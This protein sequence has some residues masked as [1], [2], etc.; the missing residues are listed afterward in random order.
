MTSTTTGP[1]TA[2]ES[3]QRRLVLAAAIA[4]GIIA[5]VPLLGWSAGRRALLGVLPGLQPINPNAALSLLLLA[6][7]L[8]GATS[9]RR[10]VR[11]LALATAA[12]A[13]LLGLAA[14][15]A[16]LGGPGASLDVLAFADVGDARPQRMVPLSALTRVV[17]GVAV[18]A[19]ALRRLSLV[20]LTWLVTPVALLSAIA[21]LGHVFGMAGTAEVTW[22]F[23]RRVLSPA[24]SVVVLLL[25][26]G[27]T[28]L[29]L[30]APRWRL[31][32]SADPAVALARRLLV[33]V[34][35]VLAS[36]G[37]V[38]VVGERA[39]WYDAIFGVAFMVVGNG[40]VLTVIIGR[41]AA[42]L[43]RQRRLLAEQEAATRFYER[44]LEAQALD[45]NDDV[46]QG[47]S[48]AWLALQL[49]RT[50]DAIQAV[51]AATSR[52]QRI[53]G[54]LLAAARSHGDPIEPGRLRRRTEP[55]GSAPAASSHDGSHGPARPGNPV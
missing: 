18:G 21:L 22:P 6:F 40:V 46:V 27:V 5:T 8:A 45:L 48:R 1:D 51:R 13:A 52:A 54:E 16:D 2:I 23:G 37:L 41:S 28:V 15:S 32:T 10:T 30:P 17:L 12:I 31:V 39:G 19:V 50:D 9:G 49:D 25:A 14:L 11:G 53:A 33:G 29:A 7:A 44:M 26:A 43:R 55:T 36:I 20:A 35:L 38:R 42:E 34:W 4:A 3:D 24:S 47:L